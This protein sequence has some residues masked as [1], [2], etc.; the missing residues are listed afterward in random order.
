MLALHTMTEDPYSLIKRKD[1]QI[2]LSLYP[3][4]KLLIES[5]EDRLYWA[6]KASAI[7]NVLDSAINFAYDIEG[8]INTELERPFA[9]CDISMLEQRLE[10]AKRILFIGDNTGET[11]F[12]C[13]LLDQFSSLDLIYAVRSAPIINDATIQDAQASCL[14]QFARI[15]STGCDAP[16]V[17]LDECSDKFLDIFYSAD[18]VISKGQ[19][20]YETLSDCNRDIFFLLKAKCPVIAKLLGIGAHEYIFKLIKYQQSKNKTGFA[21]TK[22]K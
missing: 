8:N 12:D 5:K 16:G 10:T 15:I 7:G 3:Q 11:V 18:I 1:L 13:I 14:D 17:L 19:G 21:P 22:D 4:L 9:A 6:L 2:V 20:N